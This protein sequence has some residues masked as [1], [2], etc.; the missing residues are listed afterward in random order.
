MNNGSLD[1]CR[2][3]QIQSYKRGKLSYNTSHSP[4]RSSYNL[5]FGE[6]HLPSFPSLGKERDTDNGAVT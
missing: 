3:A 2:K 4:H 6:D 5:I 1:R